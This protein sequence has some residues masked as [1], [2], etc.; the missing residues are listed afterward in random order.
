MYI[1]AENKIEVSI[2]VI[3]TIVGV[4]MAV[5]D[6][7]IVDIMIPRLQGPLSTDLYGVQWVITAYMIA[8]AIAFL[9]THPII[10]LIG[11]KNT[12]ILGIILFTIFSFLCG[13][14]NSL[15]FMIFSRAI[16]GFSEALILV[17]AKVMIF[18][19]FPP[20]KKG[21][22]MGVFALGVA[23]APAIGPT[24]GGYLT[25][26]FSWRSAFFI[27]VPIG[28]VLAIF[29]SL[30]LP[31]RDKREI[32]T[33][34]I[35]SLLFLSIATISLLVLLSKGQEYGWLNSSFIVYLIFITIFS[36]LFFAINEIFSKHKL[37]EYRLFKNYHFTI[38]ALIFMILFGFSMYQ[39]FYLLPY[40]YEH[41]K[42]LPSSVAGLGILGFGIWIGIFSIVAGVLVDKFSP[43][44]TLSIAGILYLISTLFLIPTINYYTPFHMAIIKTMLFGVSL[45][46]FFAPIT[47][48]IL[49]N[50]GKY[51][52]Q[53]VVITDYLRFIGAGFG[54]AIATND[55]VYF[56]NKNFEGINTFQNQYL[57]TFIINQLQSLYSYAGNVLFSTYE[58]F[59][60]MNYG[61]NSIWI[62]AA[63]WGILG[64]FL[65][66]M[67]LLKKENPLS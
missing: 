59:M 18:N 49:H 38:G 47:V 1:K 31:D 23:F 34:N 15:G 3:L 64:S 58:Q 39:Y 60:A 14:S 20:E 16:Q 57:T 5:L 41:I 33:I 40:F 2:W 35:L 13:I 43:S 52:E 6:T 50:S 8:A 19:Y 11:N 62:H 12:Y 48:L 66:F 28:I 37:F 25:Q 10:K 27:N 7:T 26:Y 24:L 32:P 9:V 29:G 56:T 54:T 51:Q 21:I 45:G 22:A 42:G 44:I 61:Y 36:T 63:L 55:L 53:S 17:S 4:F 30:L 46:M 67:L 65:I